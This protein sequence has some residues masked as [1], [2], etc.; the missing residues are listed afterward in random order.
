MIT[1]VV[2]AA[3][4]AVIPLTV[5][6]TTGQAEIL[7]AIVD[8]GFNG[9]LTLPL[10]QI[11]KLGFPY[12][13]NIEVVLGDGRE[14]QVDVFLGTVV[15]E[16]QVREGTVVAAD[17]SPLIG[18]ALLSGARVCLDVTDSGPVTIDRLP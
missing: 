1:G 5:Q 16:G 7:D 11:A 17:G 6:S 18:M 10:P 14:V 15:W 9:F 2:T 8:T 4:T 13:G 3:G 12:E